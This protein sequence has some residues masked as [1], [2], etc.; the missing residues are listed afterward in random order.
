VLH[1]G[2]LEDAFGAEHGSVVLAEELHFL[3]RMHFAELDRAHWFV[4]TGVVVVALRL[5]HTHGQG[6]QHLVI[7]RQV[8]GLRVVG[9][10]VVRTLNSLVFAELLD[11]L[12]AETVT[13]RERNRLLVVVIVPFEADA[14]FENGL[15]RLKPG[16]N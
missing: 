4:R 11:A 5:T 14:A 1:L 6:G 2:V 10:F 15:H 16:L 12:E 8:F 9:Q 7:N 3:A 13:A